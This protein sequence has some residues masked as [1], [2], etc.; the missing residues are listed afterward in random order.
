MSRI[1]FERIHEIG[2]NRHPRS[3]F[4]ANR[5]AVENLWDSDLK[6]NDPEVKRVVSLVVLRV[7]DHI[8]PWPEGVE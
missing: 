1:S 8:E 5:L 3:W 7:L 2:S 6:V 4:N